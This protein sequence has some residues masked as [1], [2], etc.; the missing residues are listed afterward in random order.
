MRALRGSAKSAVV[1][2]ANVMSYDDMRET[3][4]GRGWNKRAPEESLSQLF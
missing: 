1:G 3:K 4:D 2:K